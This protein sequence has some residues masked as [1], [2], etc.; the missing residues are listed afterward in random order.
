MSKSILIVDPFSTGSLYDSA[1]QKLDYACYGVV[2][3]SAL[4]SYLILYYQG[5]GMAEAKLH[6]LDDI[7]KRFPASTI[8]AVVASVEGG[9][10]CAK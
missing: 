5:E 10:Y 2:S 7:K 1:L 4:S 9:I 3:Q 6:S 8:E